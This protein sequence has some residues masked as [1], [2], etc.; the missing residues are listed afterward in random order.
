MLKQSLIV[1]TALSLAKCVAI[2]SDI[3]PDPQ[4]P[5]ADQPSL[6]DQPDFDSPLSGI[7]RFA[8]VPAPSREVLLKTITALNDTIDKH[9]WAT[10]TQNTVNGEIN[11]FGHPHVTNDFIAKDLQSDAQTYFWIRSRVYPETF[12]HRVSNEYSSRWVGPLTYDSIKVYR[13]ALEK[14]GRLHKATARLK[15][16][17]T[18]TDGH[19]N[20]YSLALDVL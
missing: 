1:V 8:T 17:Y 3:T 16:G 6:L 7:N 19:L 20:I 12:T 4:R 10:L 15:V 14:T 2:G 18:Y 9:D 11:Y 13:E 5:T